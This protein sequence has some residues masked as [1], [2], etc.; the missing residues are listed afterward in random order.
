MSEDVQVQIFGRGL[1]AR[2]VSDDRSRIVLPSTILQDL[3]LSLSLTCQ[4]WS[5]T[6][7]KT[8]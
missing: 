4:I 7:R 6:C 8:P 5:H 1:E 2:T 3:G